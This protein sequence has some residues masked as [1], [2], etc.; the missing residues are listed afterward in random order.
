VLDWD[1]TESHT[2]ADIGWDRRL[3]ADRI[4]SVASIRI[5][6]ADGN[7]F[8][9]TSGIS[10]VYRFSPEDVVDEIYIH[11]DD[12]TAEDVYARA[13]AL[14]DEWGLIN[15]DAIERWYGEAAGTTGVAASEV[16]VSQVFADR[17][18]TI[19]ETRIGTGGPLPSLEILYSY[20]D[21]KPFL[22]AFGLYWPD[23]EPAP[24]PATEWDLSTSHTLA[25][26]DNHRTTDPFT[27]LRILLPEGHVFEAADVEYALPVDRSDGILTQLVV[28][29][30]PETVDDAYNRAI[31]LAAEWDLTDTTGINTWYERARTTPAETVYKID[32]TKAF[33]KNP[34]NPEPTLGP[35]GPTVRVTI[36]PSSGLAQPALVQFEL[37]WPPTTR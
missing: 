12:G 23:P 19:E 21:D 14:I 7:V 10:S 29:Y 20:D 1:L 9:A 8:E 4:E 36:G 27:S 30:G 31:A 11:F 25:D 34:A 16:T 35:D 6:F 5:A 15:D 37:N 28:S 33:A 13:R 18:G 22:V 24:L 17:V 2:P 32:S 26:I 3:S